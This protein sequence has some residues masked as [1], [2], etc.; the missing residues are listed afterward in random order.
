MVILA[1]VLDRP[2]AKAPES[3]PFPNVNLIDRLLADQDRLQTPVADFARAHELQTLP[4][5]TELYRHLIPFEKPGDGEQYAFQVELDKCTS[6]KACVTACHS[7]NGLDE[8]E[9]WR[10]IGLLDGGEDDPAWKQ[11]VTSA[12]HHCAEPECLHGCP[13]AAYEKDAETGIVRHLDDQCIGCEYCVLKCPYDVPKF[14]ES[15]GIVRKCDMCHQR[16]AVGEAPACVQACPNEAIRIVN[17]DVGTVRRERAAEAG[18]LIG[19]PSPAL[20]LPTTQYLGREVPETA[21]PAGREELRSEP[22][23]EPLVAMLVLTQA[24]VGMFSAGL[25]SGHAFVLFLGAIAFMAGMMAS[26]SHLGRPL[27][28]W[29]FFLGLRT[30]WL[31]REILAFGLVPPLLGLALAPSGIVPALVF[32]ALGF[33]AVFTSVMVYHDTGR[34]FWRFGLT[35]ARFFGT[36]VVSGLAALAFAGTISALVPLVVLG[37]KLLLEL[38]SLRSLGDRE[39]SPA[40]HTARLQTGP[41]RSTFILRM[42]LGVGAVA[43]LPFWPLASLVVF[44]LGEVLERRLFF[45]SVWAPRMTSQPLLRPSLHN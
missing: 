2:R 45:Q 10:D 35:G 1:P 3:G 6:C 28:A 32:G 37:G 23:H 21:R 13:V 29:R 12:C 40:Q 14:N 41:L 8:G 5:R 42:C 9:S 4:P 24:G 7:L 38:S 33:V 17:V 25:F 18:F 31:S 30:S 44:L 27:G 43:L 39:W 16:L 36:A 22:A 20:T 11:T 26:V 19:A 34:P 15:R